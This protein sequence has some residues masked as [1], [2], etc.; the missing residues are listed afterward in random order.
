MEYLDAG[1]SY[2]WCACGRSKRQP[3]CDG[4]HTGTVFS[5][6]K[7]EPTKSEKVFFCCCKRSSN[8]PFCDGTHKSI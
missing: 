5:P 6:V 2:F 4:S 8:P 1:K 3:F 7:Y